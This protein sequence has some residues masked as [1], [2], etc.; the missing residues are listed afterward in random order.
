M[1]VPAYL[2]ISIDGI[3]NVQPLSHHSRVETALQLSELSV[4]LHSIPNDTLLNALRDIFV[5]RLST[6]CPCAIARLSLG[7]L[8]SLHLGRSQRILRMGS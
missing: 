6:A 3:L 1:L 4:P 7:D 8:L 5:R 2:D